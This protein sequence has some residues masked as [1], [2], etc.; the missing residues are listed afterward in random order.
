MMNSPRD[1]I[2][3][4]YSKSSIALSLTIELNMFGAEYTN[5]YKYFSIMKFSERAMIEIGM[6]AGT[7]GA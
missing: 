3:G 7:K 4:K 5:P 2:K 1:K 6:T